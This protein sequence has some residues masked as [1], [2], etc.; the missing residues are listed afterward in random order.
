[1]GPAKRITLTAALLS[2]FGCEGALR[3]TTMDEPPVA[4][5]SSEGE[6]V[7]PDTAP[8]AARISAPRG[9]RASVRGALSIITSPDGKSRIAEGPLPPGASLE[10]AVRAAARALGAVDLALSEAQGIALGP[11]SIPALAADGRCL[12]EGQEAK[13]AYARIDGGDGQAWLVVHVSAPDIGE[14][15]QRAALAA[16]GEIRLP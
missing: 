8:A 3:E 11:T 9:S 4:E 6:A 5:A 7:S 13:V 12:L 10:E 16:I 15:T 14:A 1:M 2:L